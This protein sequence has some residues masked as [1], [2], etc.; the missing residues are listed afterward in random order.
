MKVFEKYLNEFNKKFLNSK[1]IVFYGASKDFVQLIE[2]LDILL[3]PKLDI[4]FIIDDYIEGKFDTIYSINETAYKPDGK[5]EP[6]NRS[7]EIKNADKFLKKY[8]GQK[9]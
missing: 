6:N 8:V 4:D 1:K 5:I 2:T 3:K 7:I 9:L